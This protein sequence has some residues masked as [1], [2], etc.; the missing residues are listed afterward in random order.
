MFSSKFFHI[1]VFILFISILFPSES[2]AKP[3]ALPGKVS[4]Q[5]FSLEE[6]KKVVLKSASL[7]LLDAKDST[8]VTGAKSDNL[9]KFTIKTNLGEYILKVTFVGY[10]TLFI[11]NIILKKGIES[12]TLSQIVLKS[13]TLK[14]DEVTVTADRPDVVVGIDKYTFNIKKGLVQEDGDAKDVLRNL[15]SIKVEVGGKVTMLGKSPNILLNG[16]KLRI[17]LESISADMIDKVELMHNP[18]ARYE[19]Y[20]NNGVINIILK[21]DRDTGFNGRVSTGASSSFDFKES[22]S[23]RGSLNTNYQKGKINIFTNIR[24]NVSHSDKDSWYVRKYWKNTDTTTTTSNEHSISSSPMPSANFGIDYDLT[25]K[26]LFSLYMGYMEWGFDDDDTD[27][28]NFKR[29]EEIF[30]DVYNVSSSTYRNKRLSSTLN[31]KRKFDKEERTLWF[32]LHYGESKSP[33]D[34]FS[35]KIY[36]LV[37]ENNKLVRFDTRNIQRNTDKSFTAKLDYADVFKDLFKLETGIKFHINKLERKYHYDEFVADKWN[38]IFDKSDD[39]MYSSRVGAA[40]ISLK[41]KIS[42]LGIKL[43]LRAAYRDFD[44]DQNYIDTSFS[45]QELNLIPTVHLSYS[46]GMGNSITASFSHRFNRPWQSSLNPRY[47]LSDDSLSARV[48]NPEL[49]AS[50]TNNFRLGYMY[51][52]MTGTSISASVSYSRTDNGITSISNFIN[53]VV[54][55]KPENIVSS[56]SWSLSTSVSQKIMKGWSMNIG[57]DFYQT[58]YSVPET[59]MNKRINSKTSR[60]SIYGGTS[61]HIGNFSARIGGN[62]SPKSFGLQ[63]ESKGMYSLGASCSY[64]L[65]DK[66]LSLSLSFRNLLTPDSQENIVFGDNFYIESHYSEFIVPKVSFSVSYKLTNKKEKMR[67]RRSVQGSD[68]VR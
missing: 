30:K 22:K 58:K 41:K 65:L 34:A 42:K 8:V 1:F 23:L 33:R 19:S 48:G 6:N 56:E 46:L 60:Y 35:S 63:S 61:V 7:S 26:D 37:T 15:P 36:N 64:K 43:G 10:E 47:I 57:T 66:R 39:Y 54:V 52:N 24:G 12:I 3:T 32:D 53:G 31:Y 16:K 67:F 49:K 27:K 59:F 28:Q 55:R 68:D 25:E 29:N 4:G 45:R 50:H 9:G 51:F 18:S 44:Y 2:F 17:P 38:T 62:Y 40:Y 21:K 11:P 5:V 13:N 14:T 20:S